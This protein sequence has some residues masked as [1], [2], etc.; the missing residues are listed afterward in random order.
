MGCSRALPGETSEPVASPDRLSV[1]A[2]A[3][4]IIGTDRFLVH[5]P[6]THPLSLF[7]KA[8]SI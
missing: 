3:V 8:A 7:A 6:I 5:R 2:G 4:T 1:C